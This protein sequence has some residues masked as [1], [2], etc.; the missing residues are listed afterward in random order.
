[1]V[2]AEY[3]LTKDLLP[4]GNGRIVRDL[5]YCGGERGRSSCLPVDLVHDGILCL[6]QIPQVR[7][8]W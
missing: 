7:C 1:M 6:D 2:R 8:C 5:V 3:S 4:T